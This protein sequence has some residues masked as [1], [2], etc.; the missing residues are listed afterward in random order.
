MSDPR[1]AGLLLLG[2]LVPAPLASQS[3]PPLP[4]AER[5]RLA[6]V[7][8]LAAGIRARVW[9]GWE[10]TPLAILLVGDSA[11]YL[12]GH[13][14]PSSDFA[15]IGDTLSGMDIR[16][17]PRVFDP[18]LL[19]TF[20]AVNGLPTIVVGSAKQ[21]RKSSTEWVL[22]LLH[23]HF[24]QWQYELPDYYRRVGLLDLSGGDS[25]GMWMLNFAFPYQSVEV[26]EASKHLA[27]ALSTAL[28]AARLERPRA[29]AAV[30]E[31]RARLTGHLTAAE[32]RYL[33]FQLW[34]EGTARFIEYKAASLAADMGKPSAEFV[35]LDDYQA[36]GALATRAQ[37]AL[38]R[39]LEEFDLGRNRRTSFYPLGA[40]MALLLELT[41]PG[42][43]RQYEAAPFTMSSLLSEEYGHSR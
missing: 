28:G 24:H 2:M 27:L 42:W 10:H 15:S 19:A 43:M 11:E 32:D 26:Q 3:L 22:T 34:Q 41:R 21:T 29:L 12:M 37:R 4:R 25:T 20:P 23:E 18:T 6:E 31:A 5:A 17:R 9:P 39:E 36:Y 16:L 8:R 40:A 1:C 13:P 30:I 33:E 14:R 38:R 35:A 7:V